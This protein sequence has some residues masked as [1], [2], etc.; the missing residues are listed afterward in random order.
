MW[1]Y[2]YRYRKNY[3][4]LHGEPGIAITKHHRAIF[5]DSVFFHGKGWDR[6]KHTEEYVKA[7]DEVVLEP[8][9]AGRREGLE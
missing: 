9:A 8:M 2:G 1:D 6:L 3:A 5:C 4:R 7:V